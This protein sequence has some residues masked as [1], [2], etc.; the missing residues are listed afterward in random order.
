M[1][2]IPNLSWLQESTSKYNFITDINSTLPQY[3]VVL[4][5]KY[6]C[7]NFFRLFKEYEERYLFLF[8]MGLKP[9]GRTLCPGFCSER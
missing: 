4:L 2:M 9:E 3:L 6:F 8:D 7:F 5:C 1:V